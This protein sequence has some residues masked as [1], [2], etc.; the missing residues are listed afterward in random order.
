MPREIRGWW[1]GWRCWSTA[2]AREPISGNTLAKWC[3]ATPS[4]QRAEPLLPE[5]LIVGQD[6]REAANPHHGHGSAIGK[7]VP[8]ASAHFE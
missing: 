1:G 3:G 2:N 7:A 8:R 5:V 4:K 6:V